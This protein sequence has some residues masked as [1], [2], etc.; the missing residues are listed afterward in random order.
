MET[1]TGRSRRRDAMSVMSSGQDSQAGLGSVDRIRTWSSMILGTLALVTAAGIVVLFHVSQP[2]P[3][4][5][6]AA[7]VLVLVLV[8][9]STCTFLAAG[10]LVLRGRTPAVVLRAVELLLWLDLMVL[11]AATI[12]LLAGGSLAPLTWLAAIGFGFDI[13]RVLRTAVRSGGRSR[14][15]A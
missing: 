2:E 8:G 1:P 4:R 14:R 9:L 6:A 7:D 3:G 10:A 13:A 11:G 15:P 12:V 5:L